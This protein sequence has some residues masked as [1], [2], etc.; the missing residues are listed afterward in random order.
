MARRAYEL[1]ELMPPGGKGQRKRNNRDNG[2]KGHECE[3]WA[4]G[5]EKRAS[6]ADRVDER[7]L[8]ENVKHEPVRL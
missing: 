1:K 5:F 4:A 2:C 6:G 8:G 7:E 3:R